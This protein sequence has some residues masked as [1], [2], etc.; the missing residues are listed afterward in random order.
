MRNVSII[1][2]T[3]NNLNYTIQCIESIRKYT[4]T[5]SYE[6]IVVDNA[7]TDQTKDWLQKQTDIKMILN[8]ENKGFPVGC[9]QGA[10]I[11]QKD[12]DILLLNNDTIVTTDWLKNLMICLN[13]SSDI[14]A[15]GAVSISNANL[16]GIDRPY[17]PIEEVQDYTEKNNQSSPDRWED[18]LKLIGYC[19][20]VRREAWNK[21]SGLDER[22][23]PGYY[24]DDDFSLRLLQAGFRLVLCHDCFIFHYLGTSFRKK[25]DEFYELLS[26]NQSIFYEKWGFCT[27]EF[28]RIDLQELVDIDD[29]SEKNKLRI[30]EIGSGIGI[31][32]KKLQY[33]YPTAE[34]V[35]IESDQRLATVAGWHSNVLN[36]EINSYC[37]PF[38]KHT[39]DRIYLNQPLDGWNECTKILHAMQYF[40]KSNGKLIFRFVHAFSME[41][42]KRLLSGHNIL[43]TKDGLIIAGTKDIESILHK[44]GFSGLKL[45][46]YG[47]SDHSESIEK[48]MVC[49]HK[50]EWTPKINE[51]KIAFIHCVNQEKTYENALNNWKQLAIPYG[52]EIEYI[53]I[54]KSQSICHSYNQAMHM[55]NAKYK[56]YLHQ[57]ICFEEKDILLKI[58]KIFQN[59]RKV[60]M[61]GVIGAKTIPNSANWWDSD[62]II[63]VV[64]SEHSGFMQKCEFPAPNGEYEAVKAIDGLMMA[65][66]YDIDW[67]EDILTGFHFY[68]LTQCLEFQKRGYQ[69]VVANQMNPWITHK[70]GLKQNVEQFFQ[71]E[72]IREWIRQNYLREQTIDLKQSNKSTK[73]SSSQIGDQ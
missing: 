42:Q 28:D 70:C 36:Y 12:N 10:S 15:A 67:R 17:L 40:L 14:G 24:E 54:Y 51:K 25:K 58:L 26:R 53:P 61:I 30:L 2:L 52:Y 32:I 59:D 3:Y 4:Q 64:N 60:G 68:D 73:I 19:I 49:A 46:P 34:I 56:I 48:Y 8:Q 72:Q 47:T 63:G 33:K 35:G 45:I 27:T 41:N 21:I 44:Y 7:S 38:E 13:S 1:I 29:G 23:S 65:T 9:N 55:T 50:E 16:Q 22:F 37:Y 5:G 43:K 62:Q 69:V 18:K 39:F 20:L 71:Y 6:I 57:D 66:Q 11:A 31:F